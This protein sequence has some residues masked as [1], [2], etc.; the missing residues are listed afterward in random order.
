MISLEVT[1]Y[2]LT[3]AK[4]MYELFRTSLEG[5]RYLL[6]IEIIELQNREENKL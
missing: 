2:A 1:C 6:A 4:N 3:V 5:V